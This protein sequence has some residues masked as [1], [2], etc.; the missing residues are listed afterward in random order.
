MSVW[1]FQNDLSELSA[2]HNLNSD[3]YVSNGFPDAVPVD[4]AAQK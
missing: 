4:I 2:K 3:D 1:S